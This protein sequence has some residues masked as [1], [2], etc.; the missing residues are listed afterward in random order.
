ML[1]AHAAI[2]DLL[3]AIAWEISKQVKPREPYAFLGKLS[4][5]RP[6]P[7]RS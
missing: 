6:F 2:F 3:I 4:I 5:Q 7:F 1:A